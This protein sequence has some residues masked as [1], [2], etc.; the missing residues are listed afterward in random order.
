[1]PSAENIDLKSLLAKVRPAL[2]AHRDH[3][4]KL[5]SIV[6]QMNYK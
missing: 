5:L 6:H 1:M 4:D 3:A 2:I